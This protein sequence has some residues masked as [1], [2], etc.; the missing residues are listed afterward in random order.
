MPKLSLDDQLLA[1][2]DESPS[3]AARRQASTFDRQTEGYS[4]GVV[5]FG[6]GG[7][8]RKTLTMLRRTGME[9]IAFTDNAPATWGTTVDGLPVVSPEDAATRFGPKSIF[10]IT[11]YRDGV[12]FSQLRCQLLRLGCRHIVSFLPLFWKYPE[13]ALPHMAIELPSRIL[14]QRERIVRAWGLL[15]DDRS[16]VTFLELLRFHLRHECL[17]MSPPLPIRSIYFPEDLLSAASDEV[18]VDCGAFDG[19]TL[20]SFVARSPTF[21]EVLALEADPTNCSRLRDYV[22]GL[23]PD[24]RRKIRVLH[25]AVAETAGKLRFEGTGS[26]SSRVSEQGSVE[27]DAFSLDELLQDVEPTF[28]KMDIEGA[29][30]SA[31]RGARETMR[32]SRAIWATSVYHAVEDLWNIPLLLNECMPNCGLEIRRY[33]PEVWDTVLY[34]IPKS[35]DVRR[36]TERGS[37]ATS[38]VQVARRPC[39]VCDGRR[40]ECLHHQTFVVPD[41]YPLPSEYDVVECVD[42][43]MIFADSTATNADYAR[44]YASYSIYEAPAGTPSGGTPEWDKAR[45]KRV[46]EST[47]RLLPHRDA[48]IVDIGCANG[49]LLEV[50]RELGYRN[51]VGV[52][53]SPACVENLRALRFEAHLG[54]LEHLPEGLGEF[55]AVL[56]TAVLEHLFDVRPAIASLVSVLKD[57]GLLFIE[58]PDAGRYAE[59]LQSPFQDFNTEHINHYSAASI[60]NLMAPHGLGPVFEDHP[61]IQATPEERNPCLHVAYRRRLG[62]PWDGQWLR[63]RALRQGVDRYIAYSARTMSRLDAQVRR[64]ISDAQN[65]PIIVWGTGQLAMKLLCHTVLGTATVAAFVDGNPIKT[66]KRLRGVPVIDPVGLRDLPD[67]TPILI[68]TM[69]REREIRHQIMDL[70][71]RNPVH[72]LQAD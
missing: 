5:L 43:G 57:D 18:F 24:V 41:S 26:I 38:R 4:G 49:G 66:G 60:H 63:E 53:P 29:E 54:T 45:L 30:H 55:D 42:C 9:P 50:F 65:E 67:E 69:R 56:A 16:R 64:V 17:T 39:P 61:T 32:R 13:F 19:D 36:T 27:V 8:G 62:S 28:V 52:D 72:G 31:L 11:A 34:A 1:E 10:L 12:S 22:S 47:S 44:Y 48:R 20:R 25:A 68:T 37:G 59:F 21:R 51:L 58:V 71:L 15:G 2:L 23:D 35:R 6:A 3:D 70:G 33:M 46:A 14:E 7:L 40:V